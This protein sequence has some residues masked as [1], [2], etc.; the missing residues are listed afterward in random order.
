MLHYGDAET[1][2]SSVEVLPRFHSHKSADERLMAMAP[3]RLRR[4]ISFIERNIDGPLRV[5]DIAS[6]AGMSRCH[7]I[8]C[9]KRETGRTPYQFVIWRRT[10]RAVD[11]LGDPAIPLV[12]VALAAGF[13]S[14]AHFNQTFRRLMGDTPGRWRRDRMG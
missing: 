9:F 2:G 8:R 10:L 11:L 13:A 5:D 6:E 4:A 7:F 1:V 12:E 14:Q 3:V